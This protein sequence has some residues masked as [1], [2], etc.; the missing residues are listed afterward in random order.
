MRV[1]TDG[2]KK[3]HAVGSG[4]YIAD[5]EIKISFQ[6]PKIITASQDIWGRH[7]TDS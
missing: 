4:V 5:T 6:L 2:S 1:Y 3:K 7:V